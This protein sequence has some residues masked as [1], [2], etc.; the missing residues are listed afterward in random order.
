MHN[1]SRIPWLDYAKL[2]FVVSFV[3]TSIQRAL[4][5][6]GFTDFGYG[7]HVVDGV[8]Q[9]VTLPLCFFIAGNFF[10]IFQKHQPATGLFKLLTDKL[11][12]AFV[13]WTIIQ[14]VIEVAFSGYTGGASLVIDIYYDLISEPGTHYWV[15]IALIVHF[16][17]AMF[18][19]RFKSNAFFAW[20][21]ALS[22]GAYLYQNRL[23]NI[24]PLKYLPQYFIFF[25]A[26][27]YY[28]LHV[29]KSTKFVGRELCVFGVASVLFGII[30]TPIQ[31]AWIHTTPHSLLSLGSSLLGVLAFASLCKW[32][33][34]KFAALPGW[35]MRAV[36]PMFLLQ[37]ILGNGTRE[38]LANSF[39]LTHSKLHLILACTVAFAIPL[40]LG[41]KV[42]M[43]ASRYLFVSPPY[44]S[45]YTALV[46]TGSA[47]KNSPLL[48]SAA[49]ITGALLAGSLT[50]LELWS[51][52]I[53][54]KSLV[55]VSSG[56]ELQLSDDPAVIE[57]GG[58]LAQV[59]GCYM[60]C[61]GVKMEGNILYRK[62][63]LGVIA[64]PNLTKIFD[65]YSV[66]DLDG[67]I[68]HGVWPDQ[69]PVMRGMP[70]SAFSALSDDDLIKILSFI[71]RYPA[72]ANTTPNNALGIVNKFK[73]V[74][75]E[76]VS[77]AEEIAQARAHYGDKP[78]N[79]AAPKGQQLA[80]AAC[81]ECH[82]YDL[83]GRPAL[84]SPPLLVA[85]AYSM[86]QFKTLLSQGIKPNGEH[87][88][89]M[90]VVA[91]NRFIKLTDQE[92]GEIFDYLRS[93]E[94]AKYIG[95]HSGKRSP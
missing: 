56:R 22:V 8:L 50:A 41:S 55:S 62:P 24:Y 29:S 31:M 39:A 48:L 73:V 3:Y 42:G 10:Q 67:I 44:F 2:F 20:V 11:L 36:F 84:A 52:H 72:Q 28:Y 60:G 38:I 95:A 71:K 64:P 4:F 58:R 9:N 79:S 75:G 53:I 89:L 30:Q 1:D 63:F 77:Q 93:D 70:S 15:L 91:Q 57:Q 87:A 13:L 17:F 7:F 61:H 85:H 45:P 92:I 68:R 82:N 16:F 14:G 66:S 12:Y 34:G 47:L 6:N 23:P 43:R 32:L 25:C 37:A 90:S 46:H 54:Q 19:Q 65:K 51:R 49:L 21:A 88:G 80:R 59:Y 18:L 74:R 69:S 86:D 27:Q 81:G 78:D 35:V 76:F 26:G 83:M 33:S 94:L 40:L 5:R